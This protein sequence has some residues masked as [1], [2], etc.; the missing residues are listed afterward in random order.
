MKKISSG[1][2]YF[3][4]RIFPVIWFIMTAIF[5]LVVFVIPGVG[6][7][8]P[9]P[10]LVAPVVVGVI[11]FVV[12]KKFVFDLADEVWDAGDTLVVKLKGREDHVPLAEIMNISYSAFTNP[13]RA[14][15]TLR[16]PGLFGREVTFS[17]VAKANFSARNPIIDDLI[18][19]VDRARG[20]RQ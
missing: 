2:T 20:G 15:L 10:A 13:K 8:V 5:V 4:K 14:T 17:P 3:Y 9:L 19:R 16:H 7:N 1:S 12:M 6:V 11:G 18:E